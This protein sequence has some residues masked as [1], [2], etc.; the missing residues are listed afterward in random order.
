MRT[1]TGLSRRIALA[2]VSIALAGAGLEFALRLLGAGPVAVNPD[3]R[4][5]WA[6]HPHLGWTNRAGH[7]G[8]FDNGQ[9]RVHV[10]INA[11]GLRGPEVTAQKPASTRRVLVIGDSFAWGFG[12]EYEEIFGTRLAADLPNTDV[13]NGGVSGYSTD[14]ALLWL[15][16]EGRRYEH[17]VVVYVLSGNDDFMNHMQLAYWIYYKPSFRLNREGD[18]VLQGVP[19]LRS[20]AS[21]RFRH[22]LRSRSAIA[23][24]IEVAIAGGEA[25]FVYLADS[26][27]DP[28]DPHRLTV[29][30]VDAMRE[31]ASRAGASFVVV[32]NSQFW[33]SPSGSHARLIGELRSAGHDVID[34]E[35]EPGWEPEKMQIPGD[36][37]WNAM[38]HDFVAGL[39]GDWLRSNAKVSPKPRQIE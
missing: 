20:S 39:V 31:E 10:A 7:R 1:S 22:A 16:T 19:V 13:I 32:A 18:L 23:K 5:L 3:Q 37:H 14:Q 11:L 34:V 8:V 4:S 6:Y 2:L 30:L 35:S 25:S 17:D 24:A 12:V 28:R 26:Q 38:G 21:E 9:F 27:P 33:F 36:G 15:R 29:A